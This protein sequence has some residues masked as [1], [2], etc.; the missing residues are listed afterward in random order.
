MQRFLD[1]GA[2]DDILFTRQHENVKMDD[3]TKL[4]SYGILN[5]GEF[6][7]DE[8]LPEH[9]SNNAQVET[10]EFNM[11]ACHLSIKTKPIIHTLRKALSMSLKRSAKLYQ[12]H[13]KKYIQQHKQRSTASKDYKPAAKRRPPG[14]IGQCH[15]ILQDTSLYN[16]VF[17][18]LLN[19]I[20]VDS[21]FMMLKF[22]SSTFFR[23]NMRK[24]QNFLKNLTAADNTYLPYYVTST[25]LNHVH[26][27]C[28]AD[29]NA[30]I[31]E[32]LSKSIRA[33]SGER[34]F[35]TVYAFGQPFHW[36]G[37]KI[38]V[39]QLLALKAIFYHAI[40]EML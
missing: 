14:K 22:L 15:D 10:I 38:C 13:Q 3:I 39:G 24:L 5:P 40:F 34:R 28:Q 32:D 2:F 35:F 19:E 18:L 37:E 21:M 17:M 36:R 27:I 33:L 25:A 20:G 7:C 23:K 11:Q 16:T 12:A 1:I 9:V 31:I 29:D 30:I 8:E 4:A 6:E 26:T